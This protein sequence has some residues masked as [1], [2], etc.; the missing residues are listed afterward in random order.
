VERGLLDVVVN[1]S[2]TTSVDYELL[3]SIVNSLELYRRTWSDEDYTM[4][5]QSFNKMLESLSPVKYYPEV[6]WKLDSLDVLPLW[7]LNIDKQLLMD[8]LA[9]IVLV[10]TSSGR[11][12]YVASLK[13]NLI[14]LM[15]ELG[16]DEPEEVL[17]T[18]SSRI[19]EGEC[20]VYT[21]ILLL[22]KS[23]NP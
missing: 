11:Y 15:R 10:K 4:F 9:D 12:D 21:A 16:V 19:D 2:T 7:G 8:L 22:I 13:N 6:L 14:I 23:S 1:A 17:K 5:L 20:L 3:N 18:C